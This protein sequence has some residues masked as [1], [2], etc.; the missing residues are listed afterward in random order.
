M[1]PVKV[2]IKKR[3]PRFDETGNSYNYELLINGQRMD[4]GIADYQLTC[5][6]NEPPMLT[7]KMCP[8]VLDIH[9]DAQT[10]NPVEELMKYRKKF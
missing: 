10:K 6:A 9:V 3:A 5:N 2:E 8:D 4:V 7:V 1:K